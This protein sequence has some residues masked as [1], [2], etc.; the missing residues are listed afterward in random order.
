MLEFSE[1]TRCE[2]RVR[3]DDDD[4]EQDLDPSELSFGEEVEVELYRL[5][6]LE[7]QLPDKY[8]IEQIRRVIDLRTE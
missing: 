6:D 7:G 4:I 1:L 3:T 5:D 8:W 2:E